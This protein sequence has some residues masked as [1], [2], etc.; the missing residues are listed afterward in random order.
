MSCDHNTLI[1]NMWLS[2][3]KN[4]DKG[5]GVTPLLIQIVQLGKNLENDLAFEMCEND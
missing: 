1:S 3:K 2:K 5:V 4:F